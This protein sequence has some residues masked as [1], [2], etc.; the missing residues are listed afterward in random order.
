MKRN[1]ILGSAM[2]GIAW[3]ASLPL[4]SCGKKKKHYEEDVVA[5]QATTAPAPA[6][7]DSTRFKGCTRVQME[8]TMGNMVLALYNETPKHRENFLKLVKN[9]F[10]KD[11]L[12]HRVIQGFMVQGGDPNSKNAPMGVPLGQ[13]GQV[14]ASGK[15]VRIDAEFI[16]TFYHLKGALAAARQSDQ[17]NPLKQSSGSQFY[18]VSGKASNR[19]ELEAMRNNIAQQRFFDDPA[20]DAYR[21][22]RTMFQQSGDQA[23]W[24]RMMNDI[25]P[26]ILRYRATKNLN[27]PEWV[28]RLYE[29]S[30]G[31]PML[32]GEYTVFGQLISGFDVLDKIAAT[33]TN[34]NDDR[35]QQDVKIIRCTILP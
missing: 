27:Y 11:L 31:A 20:N 26:E 24:A 13:G 17:V 1:I 28:Q 34:P 35:P 8:T 12:F 25:Q 7:P 30:G 5:D 18:I 16:D 2:L 9:D 29:T 23:G 33:P 19:E 3:M 21:A 4:S 22:R 15:E 10:Y 6:W 14:D 32:D